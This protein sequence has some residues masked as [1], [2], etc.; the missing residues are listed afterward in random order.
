MDI[1]NIYSTELYKKYHLSFD[2]DKLPLD[3]DKWIQLDIK[4][5]DLKKV[6]KHTDSNFLFLNEYY[7]VVIEAKNN[8]NMHIGGIEY[9]IE[10]GLKYFPTFPK[11][12]NFY[13]E[14]TGETNIYID[15][16]IFD[17]VKVKK[18]P[19]DY[20][21]FP[22][23]ELFT[24][25]NNFQYSYKNLNFID[26]LD[27]YLDEH[28]V[29]VH[30]VCG[31]LPKNKIKYVGENELYLDIEKNNKNYPIYL[32]DKYIQYEFIKIYIGVK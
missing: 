30:D 4:E 20:E 18:I 1:K 25:L 19:Y 5:N 13:V 24:L 23:N 16:S 27:E 2:T 17:R 26:N 9:K 22:D 11:Y 21:Y 14:I 31:I 6:Q 7:Y 3:F 32:Y 15:P 29:V 12:H 8:F 28:L 10:K